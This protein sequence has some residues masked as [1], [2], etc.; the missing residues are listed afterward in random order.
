MPRPLLPG[1]VGRRLVGR[2][3]GAAVLAVDAPVPAGAC[4]LMDEWKDEGNDMP[5]ATYAP[6][7]VL[8]GGTDQVGSVPKVEQPSDAPPAAP[9]THGDSEDPAHADPTPGVGR[10][11]SPIRHLGHPH[12]FISGAAFMAGRNVGHD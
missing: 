11:P 4:L 8:P 9:A 7:H 2:R 3:A 1:A 5:A 10:P 6:E 12:F